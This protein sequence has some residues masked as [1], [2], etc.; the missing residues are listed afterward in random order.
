M[1]MVL[2]TYGLRGDVEP[3]GGL[4]VWLR[5]FSEK[6]RVCAPPD[7]GAAR[8]CD[9]PDSTGGTAKGGWR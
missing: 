2:S 6:V 9:A 5:A 7:C 1:R 3:V 4:A 8:E